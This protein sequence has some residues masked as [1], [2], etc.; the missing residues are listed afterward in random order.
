MC[1][2]MP[3]TTFAQPK[4]MHHQYEGSSEASKAAARRALG[5]VSRGGIVQLGEACLVAKAIHPHEC[6]AG[7]AAFM[8][9]TGFRTEDFQGSALKV[10]QDGSTHAAW[11]SAIEAALK[12]G[13]HDFQVLCNTASCKQLQ[14]RVRV[15]PL[16]PSEEEG[17]RPSEEEGEQLIVFVMACA[18]KANPGG[19]SPCDEARARAVV[20]NKAPF[21]VESV[22]A[23]WSRMYRVPEAAVLGRS[24]KVVQ[25]P[26]TD[27]RAVNQLMEAGAQGARGQETFVTYDVE[28]RR[29]WSHHTTSPCGSES[30]SVEVRHRALSH[31]GVDF[32]C[33]C[34]RSHWR[35]LQRMLRSCTPYS[36]CCCVGGLHV[37]TALPLS[38][39]GAFDRDH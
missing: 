25:G 39:P 31:A 28:G 30:F 37:L 14:L 17:E 23:G 35:A 24:L 16:R 26:G 27:M 29:F 11:E 38:P 33:D 10:L 19:P 15:T 21:H 6:L 32:V 1:E 2:R 34:V 8:E 7:N 18:D 13:A 4:A 36:Y 22:S 20:K 5:L 12:G 9:L 3:E